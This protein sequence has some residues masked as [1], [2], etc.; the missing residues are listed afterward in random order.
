MQIKT[1]LSYHLTPVRVV[2]TTPALPDCHSDLCRLWAQPKGYCQKP[3]QTL[4]GEVHS[5]FLSCLIENPHPVPRPPHPCHL[6][7]FLSFWPLWFQTPQ[8][9]TPSSGHSRQGVWGC[10]SAGLAPD[11]PWDPAA[12]FSVTPRLP[13]GWCRGTSERRITI[14]DSKTIFSGN[15][16]SWSYMET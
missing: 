11:P 4:L 9:L 3:L 5:G 16:K 12:T 14:A 15:L 7:F 2:I 10:V 8:L 1:T 6:F 13:T